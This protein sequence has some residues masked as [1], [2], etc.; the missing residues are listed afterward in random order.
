M[1]KVG[2]CTLTAVPQW[3]FYKIYFCFRWRGCL[4]I[5]RVWSWKS[6]YG[7]SKGQHQTVEEFFKCLGQP[8]IGKLLAVIFLWVCT[9]KNKNGLTQLLPMGD[10]RMHN[11]GTRQ[12][13]PIFSLFFF[14]ELDSW[15]LEVPG[16]FTGRRGI[17]QSHWKDTRTFSWQYGVHYSS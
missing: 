9:L 5:I 13:I 16:S 4:H 15:E 6:S 11:S 2:L 8:G 7:K 10:W 1:Y 17:F 3:P 12:C 14:W